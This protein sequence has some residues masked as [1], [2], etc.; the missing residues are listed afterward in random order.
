M[1]HYRRGQNPKL[2]TTCMTE[3]HNDDGTVSDNALANAATSMKVIIEDET[4][5]VVQALADATASATGKYYY[6][7]YTIA[8]NATTGKYHYAFRALDGTKGAD[9]E[10]YFIV[11][12]QIA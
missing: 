4:G 12:E 9:D 11:E 3:T 8:A 1:K 2:Y 5:E 6:D 7:G 10:G